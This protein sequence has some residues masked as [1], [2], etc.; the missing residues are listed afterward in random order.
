MGFNVL[1]FG[2]VLWDNI[3]GKY[4]LGGAPLN[5]SGHCSRFGNQAYILSAVGHD[6][7]GAGIR[8]ELK[9]LRVSEEYLQTVDYPTG[10]VDVSLVNG[11]PSYNIKADC[12][13]DNIEL[14]EQQF[15][16]IVNTS[17]DL[18][19]MGTL[20]LRSKKNRLLLDRLFTSFGDVKRIFYDINLRQNFYHLEIIIQCLKRAD[21]VKLNDEEVI[22]LKSLFGTPEM[23]D[24]IFFPQII[25]DYNIELLCVTYGSRGAV[26]YKGIERIECIPTWDLPVISTVGAGDSFSAALIHG[27]I[28]TGSIE[29]AGNLAILI[30]SYVISHNG[31]LPGYDKSLYIRIKDLIK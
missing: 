19:Y 29:K 17:W 24:Q 21:I 18:F 5:F 15:K 7:L 16:K 3:D 25:N 13:W 28:T 2:E 1:T 11:I 8:Q 4:Y 30:A 12:A 20:A 14:K 23:D 6:D 27:Y 22:V 26:L 9:E 31:A 10:T